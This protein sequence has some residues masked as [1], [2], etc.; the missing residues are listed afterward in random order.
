[1]KVYNFWATLLNDFSSYQKEEGFEKG[2]GTFHPFCDELM[3]IDRLNRVQGEPTEA[4]KKGVAF[5]ECLRYNKTSHSIDNLKFD[6]D[7]KLLESMGT[8]CHN[9]I[10]NTLVEFTIPV[11]TDVAVRLYGYIDCIKQDTCIDV[12]TTS[13]YSFP[14]F[15]Q[16]YQHKLYMIASNHSGIYLNKFMYLITDFRDYYYEVY[17]YDPSKY[18]NDLIAISKDLIGFIESRKILINNP[19][20]ITIS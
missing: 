6:F 19:R 14:K 20:L 17:P 10:W 16:S 11:D 3:L 5:E 12:K 7:A 9:G 2:D 4:M 8:I 1:M 15:D 13:S 18:M